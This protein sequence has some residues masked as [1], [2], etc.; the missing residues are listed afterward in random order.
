MRA[1]RT[2]RQKLSFSVAG[3][4]WLGAIAWRELPGVVSLGA[5]FLVLPPLLGRTLLRRWRRELGA[6]RYGILVVLLLF[7]LTLPGKMILRWAF[8]L[9]F[10][11]RMPEYLL[12]F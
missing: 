10:V 1:G 9:S 7:M 12:N 3:L 11:L 4:P 8:N 6:A 2:A 5:Y